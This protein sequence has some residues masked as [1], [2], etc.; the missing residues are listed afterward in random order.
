MLQYIREEQV[1]LQHSKVVLHYL[2]RLQDDALFIDVLSKLKNHSPIEFDSHLWITRQETAAT[3]SSLPIDGTLQ[4]HRHIASSEN[5]T[6]QSWDWWNSFSN[7]ALEHFDTKEK[8]G[9][10][11]TYICGPQGLTDRLVDMYN[12][13]GLSTVDG[14][15]Q[16]EKWW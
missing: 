3:K 12:E 11:L 5:E 14:H 15:V 10:S 6:G 4:V 1:L 9:K 7:Q 13:R 8:R 16:V 2:V